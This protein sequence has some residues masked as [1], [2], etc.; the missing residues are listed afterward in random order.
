MIEKITDKLTNRQVELFNKHFHF[1]TPFTLLKKIYQTNDR[2]EKNKLVSIINSGLKDLKEEAKEMTKLDKIIK[3]PDLIEN[4]VKKIL[5]V[6][7][8]N[9]Q[10]QGIKIL[11]PN[12]MLNRLPITLAQLQAGNNTNK[13]KTEIR[14]LLYS[15]YR[16]TNITE[17]VYKSLI[18]T[19]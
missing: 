10:G 13:L 18:G 8:K 19:I 17:Q 12:Q 15:L 5:K 2:E 4:I 3:D 9:Q 7:E 1:K 6:N 14:Q 11:T 16:S